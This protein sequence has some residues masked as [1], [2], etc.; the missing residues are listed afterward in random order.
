MNPTQRKRPRRWNVEFSR[1]GAESLPFEEAS[2]DVAIVNGIFN[3]NPAR[4]RIFDELA[5]VV[6]PGGCVWAAELILTAP[7]PSTSEFDADNWFA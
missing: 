7:L 2:F 1:A 3:L 6:R 5:R 4:E